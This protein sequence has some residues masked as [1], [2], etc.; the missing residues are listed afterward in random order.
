MISKKVGKSIDE[1]EIIGSK[2]LIDKNL[3]AFKEK[4]NSKGNI[5]TREKIECGMKKN[6]KKKSEK[7]LCATKKK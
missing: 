5:I 1:E 3:P 7:N 6:K 2:L 4:K